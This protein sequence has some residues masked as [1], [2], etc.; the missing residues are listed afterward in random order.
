LL[1]GVYGWARFPTCWCVRDIPEPV[2]V[3]ME[4]VYRRE[5]VKGCP[6]AEDDAT[7]FRA[8][9]DACAYWIVE[10]LA[11]MLDR[12]LE[13]SE[14]RGTSTNR[15]RILR[16]LAAFCQVAQRSGHLEAMRRT[17][18]RL[19]EE[20]RRRWQDEMPLYDAFGQPMALDADKVREIV[21]AVS[22]GQVDRVGQMLR[23]NP[24]LAKAK[25]ADADLLRRAAG[26]AGPRT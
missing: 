4:S 15:Q 3:Q 18:E 9:A 7:Y 17:C 6:A 14:P 2:V 1:D 12:A 24:A 21:A 16:R 8:V 13:Y 22:K 25:D 5:L 26:K 23:R 19:L 20:L 11:H 10:S